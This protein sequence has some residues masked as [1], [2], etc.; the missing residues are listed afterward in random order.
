MN[1][2]PKSFKILVAD[3]DADDRALINDA[4]AESN[5]SIRMDSV[6]DGE[7]LM[8]YLHQRGRYVGVEPPNLLILDLNMPRKNGYEALKE[9]RS[10]P[11]FDLMPI[12]VFTTSDLYGDLRL[13]YHDGVNTFF[14]KPS[15]FAALTA[16]IRTLGA[17]WFQVAEVPVQPGS[18]N[19]TLTAR[20]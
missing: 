18:S 14:K 15:S 7:E 6:N 9:I 10:D 2:L 4:L 8:D 16:L 11:T 13:T 3:D 12:V 5:L 20:S 17:Y 1:E 19:L